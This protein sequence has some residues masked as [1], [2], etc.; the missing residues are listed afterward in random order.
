[1]ISGGENCGGAS[2]E[3]P[4]EVRVA[5]WKHATLTSNL[6]YY[7]LPRGGEADPFAPGWRLLGNGRPTPGRTVQQRLSLA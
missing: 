2:V 5:F 7:R 1:M 4:F 6:G 3:A